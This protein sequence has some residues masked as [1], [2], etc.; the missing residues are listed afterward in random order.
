LLLSTDNL[1]DVLLAPSHACR[2]VSA[3]SL[4]SYVFRL[5]IPGIL[6]PHPSRSTAGTATA[7]C[8]M[9]PSATP[10]PSSV[11]GCAWMSRPRRA[12]RAGS[13]Q[14]ASGNVINTICLECGCHGRY[15][16]IAPS[17]KTPAP[18]SASGLSAADLDETHSRWTALPHSRTRPTWFM[19]VN[20]THDHECEPVT[21]PHS[22]TGSPSVVPPAVGGG[23]RSVI[24]RA[25]HPQPLI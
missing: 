3:L 10:W 24:R 22:R 4:K 1:A 8:A 18:V 21:L 20:E 7:T 14:G 2:C 12:D 6:T 19:S 13:G 17:E 16:S 15:P 9:S 5:P 25:C 11:P 23:T